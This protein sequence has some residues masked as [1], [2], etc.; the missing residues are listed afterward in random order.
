MLL[1]QEEM[2]LNK[3]LFRICQGSKRYSKRDFVPKKPGGSLL[4][5]ATLHFTSFAQGQLRIGS[6]KGMI[7]I[8]R[9]R[10][11][12]MEYKLY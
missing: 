6:D 11:H 10:L 12:P 3:L 5:S 7:S 9:H 1:N 8:S 4:L 2:I